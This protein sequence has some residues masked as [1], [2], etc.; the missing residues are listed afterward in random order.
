MLLYEPIMYR[1]NSNN[2]A[3]IF[4]TLPHHPR[5]AAAPSP[6]HP[7]R[8]AGHRRGPGSH[9]VLRHGAASLAWLTRRRHRFLRPAPG[10]RGGGDA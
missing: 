4:L 7:P 1:L 6:R 10:G 3:P 9:L 5:R 2:A 8:L